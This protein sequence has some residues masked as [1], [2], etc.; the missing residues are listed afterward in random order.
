MDSISKETWMMVMVMMM[1]YMMIC[2]GEWM[3]WISEEYPNKHRCKEMTDKVRQE[4]RKSKQS[5]TRK[6]KE[7]T[8]LEKEKRKN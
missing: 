1:M 2:T 3:D 8:K 7:Q 5:K 4:N 6:Q